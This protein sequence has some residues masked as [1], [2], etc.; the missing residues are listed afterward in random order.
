[1]VYILWI[2]LNLQS[3]KAKG[4]F[5]LSTTMQSEIHRNKKMGIAVAWLTYEKKIDQF[6]HI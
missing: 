1:M 2:L 4:S 3:V 6:D 5:L